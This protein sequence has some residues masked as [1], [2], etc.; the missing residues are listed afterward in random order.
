M[1]F[2]V[3]FNLGSFYL[4]ICTCF[5]HTTK[6]D[7]AWH[8]IWIAISTLIV[9]LYGRIFRWHL[10]RHVQDNNWRFCRRFSPLICYAVGYAI[11][12][13]PLVLKCFGVN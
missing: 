4:G 6:A 1:L 9:I 11:V 10:R 5:A 8:A 13:V 2:D 7:G 12:G 3:Y